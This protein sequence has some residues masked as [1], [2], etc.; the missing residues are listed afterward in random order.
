[1][2]RPKSIRRFELFWWGS[3]LF[4]AVATRLAW[5]RNQG[6]LLADA[7]TRDVAQWGQWFW[8]GVTVLLTALL[9]WLVARRASAIGKWLVVAW[10]ALGGVLALIRVFSLTVGR[11]FHP[12]SESAHLLTA[13]LSVAA[14]VMLFRDDARAWFG[15]FDVDSDEEG[16]A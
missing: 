11:T 15:E 5:D 14:A 10:S 6:K 3:A 12:F 1:M 13:I 4:W 16:S 7:R 8:I 9:W 2:D